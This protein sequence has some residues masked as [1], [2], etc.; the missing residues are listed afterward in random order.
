MRYWVAYWTLNLLVAKPGNYQLLVRTVDL[1]DFAQ[2]EP[3]P[4]QWTGRNPVPSKLFTVT[5]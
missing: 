1:N 2:P 4:Q 5:D 3:R